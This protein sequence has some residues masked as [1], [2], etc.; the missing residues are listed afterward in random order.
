MTRAHRCG[1][2]RRPVGVHLSPSE[3]KFALQPN[4]GVNL[5]VTDKVGVRVTADYRRV[6]LGEHRGGENEFRFAMGVVLSFGK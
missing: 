1:G 6:F 4:I 3:T 2:W 5:M